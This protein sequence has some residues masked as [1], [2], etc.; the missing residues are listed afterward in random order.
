V[1]GPK[2]CPPSADV[3]RYK[4]RFPCNQFLN[5]TKTF[6]PFITTDGLQHSHIVLVRR[7]VHQGVLHPCS[8]TIIRPWHQIFYF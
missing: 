6:R 2:V 5:I 7:S 1:P 8:A 3:M 4:S